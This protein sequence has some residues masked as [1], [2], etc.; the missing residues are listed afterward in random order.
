Q[1]ELAFACGTDQSHISRIENNQR[2]PEF[3]TLARICTALRL[4]PAEHAYV[5]GLAGYLSPPALPDEAAVASILAKL[6]PHMEMIPYPACLVDDGVRQWY[7]NARVAALWGHLYGSTDQRQC[8]AL[9]AGRRPVEA[10]FDPDR[11]PE[12]YAAWRATYE[13][14]DAVLMSVVDVF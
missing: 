11:W 10:V 9:S 14:V 12:A 3:A 13:N 5:F 7:L 4:T 8:L 6:A 1:E 2:H